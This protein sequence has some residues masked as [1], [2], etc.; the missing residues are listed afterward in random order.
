MGS[1]QAFI[2]FPFACSADGARRRISSRFSGVYSTHFKL[3]EPHKSPELIF[4]FQTTDCW[5]QFGPGH[6]S[7]P[8]RLLPHKQ[9]YRGKKYDRILDTVGEIWIGHWNDG[10]EG[11]E[12]E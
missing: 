5:Q 4:C 6:G 2:F 11:E 9:Q 3:V 1:G 7:E 8:S 12:G 10:L